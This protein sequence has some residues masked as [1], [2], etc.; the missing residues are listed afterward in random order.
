MTLL[1]QGVAAAF[2]HKGVDKDLGRDALMV[3]IC[4]ECMTHVCD[5]KTRRTKQYYINTSSMLHSVAKKH[6]LVSFK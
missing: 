1:I 5:L 3:A 6:V 2:L 4:G